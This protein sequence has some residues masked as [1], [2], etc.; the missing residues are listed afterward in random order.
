MTALVPFRN[1]EFE[2]TVTPDG[3]NFRD[4]QR[5]RLGRQPWATVVM[6]TTVGADG[7]AR[8]MLTVDRRTFTMWLATIDTGRVKSEKSRGLI[9][10]YQREAADALD[11]YFHEGAAINAHATEHQ[12][13][14][15]IRRAQ[16]AYQPDARENRGHGHGDQAR[17]ASRGEEGHRGV[18]RR[19]SGAEQVGSRS[20]IIDPGVHGC[21]DSAS[22][23]RR[24]AWR[25]PECD[26][27][28]SQ[29]RLDRKHPACTVQAGGVQSRMQAPRLHPQEKKNAGAHRRQTIR[30]SG[31]EHSA[32]PAYGAA[33]P[34]TRSAA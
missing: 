27:P 34:A 25:T 22:G 13:N 23:D 16:M 33:H 12:L 2:L 4:G 20:A 1:E 26:L 6:T 24:G 19:R 3:D 28:D 18:A 15:A 11:R 10:A 21:R 17:A 5:R 7:K 9:A 14:A 8:E 30:P 32:A 31:T 29:P